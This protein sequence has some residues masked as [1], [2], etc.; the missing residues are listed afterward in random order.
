MRWDTIACVTW[1][2]LILIHGAMTAQWYVPDIFQPHVLPF[3]A[4][5]LGAIF[6]QDKARPHTA[7]MSQ[8][9]LCH[10]TTLLC[11]ARYLDLSPI[12]CTWDHLG[13]QARLPTSL[14]KLEVRLQQMWN[15]MFL[16]I[17]RN[18]Y[19]SKPSRIASHIRARRGDPTEC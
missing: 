18:L 10:I 5:L 14:V 13:R 11:P 8:D 6:Q 19:A 7:R 2:L 15:E 1:S 12:E 3:M 4:G 16:Y 17:I 9:F